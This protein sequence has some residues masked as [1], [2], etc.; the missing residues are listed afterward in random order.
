MSLVTAVL[1]HSLVE[2]VLRIA[3]LALLAGVAT[4]VV[5]FVYRVR[6]RTQFPEGATLIVG[7]GIVAIYL[8]TRLVFVQFVGTGGDLFSVGEALLNVAVFFVAGIASYAGRSVGDKMGTSDRLEWGWL[9]PNFSPIVR[10]AGRFITVTLPD[11]IDDIVGYDPVEEKTKKAL[12]GRKFDFP[13]GLTVDELQSQLGE[14]LKQDHDI[15]YV[16]VEL[17]GDGEIEYLAVGQRPAG[18]GPTLPPQSAAVAVRADPPFSATA[19]D[20]VQLWRASDGAEKRLGTAELRASV[21]KVA[22]VAVDEDVAASLDPTVDHR[23][24]TLSADSYP[25]REFTTMLRQ[26]DETMN[27]V[28]VSAESQLIGTSVGALDVTVIAI[29]AATGELNTIPKRE[30]V[31]QAGDCLFAIGRPDRLRKL[32]SSQGITAADSNDIIQSATPEEV[33][34]TSMGEP[35]GNSEDH[36]EK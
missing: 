31:I 22:T 32:E 28:E 20:T 26:S 3:G 6:V 11:D 19:G 13:R 25:D 15:G 12:A 34:S 9:Q 10:A 4:T 35:T 16:D 30:H 24:M 5:T 2:V 21:G 14:R 36:P 1:S 29:R 18:L 17:T 33:S 8:N 7:L 23:L 27:I